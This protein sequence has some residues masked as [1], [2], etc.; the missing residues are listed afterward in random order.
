MQK[1]F[2]AVC[3]KHFAAPNIY[4]VFQYIKS[5]MFG[6][7]HIHAKRQI[8]PNILLLFQWVRFG[9]E[10]LYIYSAILH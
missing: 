2:S 8:A 9:A 10:S 5:K 6:A 4:E 7:K 3:T 1:M